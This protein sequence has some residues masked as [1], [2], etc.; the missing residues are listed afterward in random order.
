[1]SY[2]EVDYG[3]PSGEVMR[4]VVAALRASP[5]A[6]V[7]RDPAPDCLLTDVRGAQQTLAVRYW[8]TDLQRQA[9]IDSA[10]RGRVTAAL[11]RMGVESSSPTQTVLLHPQDRKLA[12]EQEEELG[13]RVR[14]L[15]D[16][17]IFAP[18]TPEERSALAEKLI[19]T[20]F[21]AGEIV[22]REGDSAE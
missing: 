5:L 14:A 15:T 1:W 7:A 13:R 2:F 17:S 9:E 12:L 8:L 4:G 20:R 21:S 3:V 18:L 19:P 16:V 10:I 22:T 6:G 11:Q